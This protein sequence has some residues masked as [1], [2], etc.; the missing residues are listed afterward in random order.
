[1]FIPIFGDIKLSN[2]TTLH[3]TNQ[4]DTATVTGAVRPDGYT[5]SFNGKTDTYQ[6]GG[7]ALWKRDRPQISA[8]VVYTATPYTA[9]L[10]NVHYAA[11]RPPQTGSTTLREQG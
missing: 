1:M 6:V 8:D 4:I 2:V 10:R 9:T 5:G 7:G 11:A 3:G